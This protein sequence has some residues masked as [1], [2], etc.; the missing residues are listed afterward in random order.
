MIFSTHIIEDVASSCNRVAVMKEGAVQYLGEPLHMTS[1][2]EGR[3]WIMTVPAGEFEL[4][5]EKYVIIHHLSDGENIR[6]RCISDDA[7]SKDAI[8]ARANLEDAYLCLLSQN[9]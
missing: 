8:P 4:V 5:K 1:I 9:S 3:V 2:A 6:L 7:P